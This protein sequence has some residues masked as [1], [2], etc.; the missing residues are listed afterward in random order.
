ELLRLNSPKP[1][2]PGSAYATGPALDV[3]RPFHAGA[4]AGG[5]HAAPADMPAS[6]GTRALPVLSAARGGVDQEMFLEDGPID[7]V[8]VPD[9]LKNAR[10]S[11]GMYVVGESMM[12]RF[13][14]QQLLY[15]NPYK[16]PAPGSGVVVVK[17]SKAVLVKEF[18]RRAPMGI[19]VRE[20][21]PETREFVIPL[22]ELEAVHT[23]VGLQE[24]S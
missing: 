18:V 1:P 15:V 14:P 16:P 11:Y 12:P 4:S 17:T 24:P 22:E 7:W 5:R 3:S 8:A 20:Y 21:R 2:S 6:A 19:L 10:D 23:V 13:R 9:Y